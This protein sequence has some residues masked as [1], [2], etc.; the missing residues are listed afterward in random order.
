MLRPNWPT[1]FGGF[2]N[3]YIRIARPLLFGEPTVAAGGAD[4]IGLMGETQQFELATEL[5]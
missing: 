3:P 4:K 5:V 2:S 1:A